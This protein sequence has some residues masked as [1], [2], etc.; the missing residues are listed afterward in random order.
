MIKL[1][2]GRSLSR[3]LPPKFMIGTIRSAMGC[4]I[5]NL[6]YSD[7][8]NKTWHAHLTFVLN[9]GKGTKEFGAFCGDSIR[10][11]Y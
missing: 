9:Q 7:Q 4:G 11:K 3:D 5:Q 8:I 10:F 6:H 2:L 1:L